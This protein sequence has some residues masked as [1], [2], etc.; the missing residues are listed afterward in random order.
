MRLQPKYWGEHGEDWPLLWAHRI[1]INQSNPGKRSHQVGMMYDIYS[2]A[3]E[4][5]V[6]L[7]RD[8]I[9]RPGLELLVKMYN[10]IPGLDDVLVDNVNYAGYLSR[11]NRVHTA[12]ASC[13]YWKD[14]KNAL[15]QISTMTT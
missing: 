3:R 15:W 4:V 12:D 5:T 13:W 6:C 2:S 8:S 14:W 10:D 11:R 1:C 7:T 9:C